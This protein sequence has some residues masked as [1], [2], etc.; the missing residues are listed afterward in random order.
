MRLDVVVMDELNKYRTVNN[1][2]CAAGFVFLMVAGLGNYVK[3]VSA[4]QAPPQ[5]RRPQRI[6]PRPA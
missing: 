4:Y 6:G 3:P 1:Y 5:V 2:L